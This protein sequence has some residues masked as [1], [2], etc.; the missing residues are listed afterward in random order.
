MLL[1]RERVFA[2]R[3]KPMML[4]IV[5]LVFA[6]GHFVERQVGDFGERGVELVGGFFLRRFQRWNGVFQRRD[7]GQEPFARFLVLSPS[8]PRRFPS[9][10][11]FR[12]ACAAS[13]AWIARRRFSSSAIS[14]CACGSSP[15]RVSPRSKASGFSRMKRMSCMNLSRHP[16]VRAKSAPRR[17]TGPMPT[18]PSPFEA[19]MTVGIAPW[20][21]VLTADENAGSSPTMTTPNHS[22]GLAAAAAS[23]A[24]RSAAARFST[25]RTDQTEPSYKATSGSASDSW[26]R[27]IG[28]RQHRGDHKGDDDEIAPLRFEL[29]GGDDADPAEQRQDHRK[30]EGD[31]EGQHELHHQ[32]QVVLDLRQ[33]FDRRLRRVRRAAACRARSASASARRRNRRWTRRAQRRSAWR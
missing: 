26:L 22:A 4:D 7:F 16:E 6:V 11:A 33:Q 14:R 10:A 18:R 31:A 12:R 23:A 20:V 29:V 1:R 13:A 19:P 9:T 32:R 27:H 25:Q 28:R 5:V 2:L 30:L 3:S 17:M 24:A 8:W 15:R 21:T